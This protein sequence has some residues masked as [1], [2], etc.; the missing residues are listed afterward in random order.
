[1]NAV[2]WHARGDVRF[3][4]VPIP[5]PSEEQVLIRVE[6]TGICGTDVD[7]VRMGPVTVPV[8][9][10]P[11][12]GRFA[13]MTL[14]HEIV[15]FV[16]DAGNRTELEVG[17]RVAPW[18]LSTCG[19]CREC[20]TGHANRCLVMVALG[21][22]ADGG[23]AEFVVANGGQCVRVDEAVDVA[24]AVLIE[25]FAV[26]L[27]GAHQVDVRGARVAVVGIGS[28]GLCMV[29]VALEMGVG[30]VVGLSRSEQGREWAVAAGASDAVPLQAASGVDADIV[31]EA[32]GGKEAVLAATLAA[33]RGGRIVI[34]GAH[35]ESTPMDLHDLVVRELVVQGSV[36]HCLERDFV[37]AARLIAEGRLARM[38]R[39]VVLAPLR[40]G[41]ALLREPSPR[42]KGILLPAMS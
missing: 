5:S 31:F 2:R 29:E 42:A 37:A 8:E 27:H 1:M 22:S 20:R 12:S 3:D 35:T 30:E 4:Q 9:P 7:E 25:P 18:P 10:H 41:P 34:L 32:A 15:G 26:T 19:T 17:A 24:R 21:M 6:A 33:R 39:P 38:A 28:L 16:A 36:S 40:D 11:V 14:G 23:M 13:P